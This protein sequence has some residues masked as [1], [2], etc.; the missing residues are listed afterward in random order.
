MKFHVFFFWL[1]LK[2]KKKTLGLIGLSMG[3]HL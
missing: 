3:V 1:T 2:K